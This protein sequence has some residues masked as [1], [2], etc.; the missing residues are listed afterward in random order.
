MDRPLANFFVG[1]PPDDRS[2]LV[3]NYYRTMG[4]IFFILNVGRSHG[5]GDYW[6]GILM[7]QYCGLSRGMKS[8]QGGR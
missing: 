5:A 1:S 4:L 2:C 6:G 7:I 3:P 8:V